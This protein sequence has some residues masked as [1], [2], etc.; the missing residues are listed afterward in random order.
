MLESDWYRERLRT[1]QQRDIALFTRHRQA[2]ELRLQQGHTSAQELDERHRF[3]TAELEHVSAA[4]YLE[5]LVGT[6][7]ADPFHAQMAVNAH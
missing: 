2:L 7:G 6:L 3:V 5:E 1:K 4:S